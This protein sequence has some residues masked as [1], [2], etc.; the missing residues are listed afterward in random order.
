MDISRWVVE[1][2][3]RKDFHIISSLHE[4]RSP[5]RMKMWYNSGRTTGAEVDF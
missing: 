2:V 4:L 5:P 1:K 3:M